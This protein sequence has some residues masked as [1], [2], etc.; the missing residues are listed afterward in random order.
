V[1]AGFH[2]GAGVRNV[3]PIWKSATTLAKVLT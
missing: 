3:S 1:G 2:A